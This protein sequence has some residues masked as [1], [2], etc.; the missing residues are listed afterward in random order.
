MS[1]ARD[2]TAEHDTNSRSRRRTIKEVLV[3]QRFRAESDPYVEFA[4]EVV[5]GLETSDAHPQMG[6]EDFISKQ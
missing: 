6:A 4:D 5:N 1:R 2:R 3:T